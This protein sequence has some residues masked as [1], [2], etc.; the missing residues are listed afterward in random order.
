M[1]A[2]LILAVFVLA[3][4][5]AA[6]QI[7]TL[8]DDLSVIGI[9]PSAI[10]ESKFFVITAK[11]IN[12][13]PEP[14][15]SFKIK[16]KV[17]NAGDADA[18]VTNVTTFD[19]PVALDKDEIATVRIDSLNLNKDGNYLVIA[20]VENADPSGL[21]VY[22]DV[23]DLNNWFLQQIGGKQTD[24]GVFMIDSPSPKNLDAGS[25]YV[26]VINYGPGKLESCYIRWLGQDAAQ[27]D[28]YNKAVDT[29]ASVYHDKWNKWR[30]SYH[31]FDPPLDSGKIRQIKADELSSIDGSDVL[32]ACTYHPNGKDDF[33]GDD[34]SRF[35]MSPDATVK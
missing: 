30:Y 31:V 32:L 16:W 20:G 28:L 17:T 7:I 5:G 14:V 24:V 4:L 21:I 26:S 9:G 19:L 1:K 3:S 23:D 27:N 18:K 2:M 22:E 25:L 8:K 34:T 15:K 10:Q 6:A 11:V 29:V 35:W 12:Y 13:G 33:P